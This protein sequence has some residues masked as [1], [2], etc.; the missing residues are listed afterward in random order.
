MKM[1]LTEVEARILVVLKNLMKN[2]SKIT[3]TMVSK[4]ADTSYSHTKSTIEKFEEL[5]WVRSTSITRFKYVR[6]TDNGMK[7]A[8]L[9][10]ALFKLL[11]MPT[12]PEEILKR[13]INPLHANSF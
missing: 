11:G 12:D 8:E 7:V 10:E 4:Y 1:W 3:V 13:R 2:H 6:L 5:R 9:C